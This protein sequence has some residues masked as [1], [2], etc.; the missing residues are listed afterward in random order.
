VRTENA[1]NCGDDPSGDQWSNASELYYFFMVKVNSWTITDG[2]RHK[3]ARGIWYSN[4]EP[5]QLFVRNDGGT[6]K[7]ELSHRNNGGTTVYDIGS[8]NVNDTGWH[9]VIVR[10][11]SNQSSGGVAWKVDGNSQTISDTGTASSQQTA[12]SFQAGDAATSGL[13]ALN[14]EF[15]NVKVHTSEPT[16]N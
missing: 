12:I 1:G 10:F 9:K 6:L 13:T 2:T 15:D 11:Q 16:C 4:S 14:V 8:T 3:I 5:W 7:Y